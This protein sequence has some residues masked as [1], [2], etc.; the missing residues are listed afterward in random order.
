MWCDGDPTPGGGGGGHRD[1]AHATSSP[2]ASLCSPVPGAYTDRLNLGGGG[3]ASA[4]GD[5]DGA[6]PV[7][8]IARNGDVRVGAALDCAAAGYNAK[9]KASGGGGGVVYAAGDLI[10]APQLASTGLAQVCVVEMAVC[11][12]RIWCRNH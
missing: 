2:L 3:V 7:S 1:D 10:G 11:R 5:G 6:P 12:R 9:A 4:G 8:V